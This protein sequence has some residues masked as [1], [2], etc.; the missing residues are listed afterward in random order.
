MSDLARYSAVELLRDGREIEI[1]ALRPSDREQL[2][3][4]ADR[5]SRESLYRRFFGAKRRFTEQEI[6]FYSDVDLE[7]QVALVAT[8]KEAGQLMIVAGARY[9]VEREGR[10]EMAVTVIDQYQRQGIGGKLL[11]HLAA[12]AR[13]QGLEELVAN[14]Q[15]DNHPMLNTFER[16]GLDI[17]KL[18]Q[19]GVIQ[20]IVRLPSMLDPRAET[21]ANDGANH[22]AR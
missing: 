19:P 7:S 8:V 1:R 17:R 3:A 13:R 12:I 5:A 21:A 9:I 16:S 18:L 4:A 10:A 6:A 11:H 20:V 15:P 2:V 22:R 14:V